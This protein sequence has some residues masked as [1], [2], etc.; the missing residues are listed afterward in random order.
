MLKS[1]QHKDALYRHLKAEGNL[2]S[3]CKPPRNVHKV[4]AASCG[5]DEL[6]KPATEKA[7]DK[8]TEAALIG[9]LTSG[10]ITPADAARLSACLTTGT[11]PDAGLAARISAAL[12][13]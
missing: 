12:K 6:L 11:P 13:G 9:A 3:Q 4:I 5:D 10:R 1:Q 7:D 2:H 8:P